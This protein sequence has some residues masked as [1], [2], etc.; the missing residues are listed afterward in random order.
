M[1]SRRFE[2]MPGDLTDARVIALIREH[3]QGMHASSPPGSVYALDLSGLQHPDVAFFTA[4][5]GEE[6]LGCAALKHLDATSGEIKSM[7]TAAAHLR[8]GVAARLLEHLLALARAR[9]YRRVSLET[10]TGAPFEAALQLYARYGFEVGAPFG[11]YAATTFN[12]FLHLA[13]DDG[14]E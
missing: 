13:I 8:K 11:D 4:W 1:V 7:R 12:R 10:G 3:L 9:R 6:L 5:Q 14:R 2:I